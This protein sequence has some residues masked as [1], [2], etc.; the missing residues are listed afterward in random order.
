MTKSRKKLVRAVTHWFAYYIGIPVIYALL[1]LLRRT[2][3]ITRGDYT[4]VLKQPIIFAVWHGEMLIGVTEIPYFKRDIDVLASRSRDGELLSRFI[5]IAGAEAI[6]GS[7]SSGQFGAIRSMRGS[8]D[9]GRSVALA[10]DGPRGPRAIVK[11][12]VILLA[13]MT[14]VPI[15]PSVMIP[16]RYWQF[17]SWDRAILPKPFSRIDFIPGEPLYVPPQANK[18]TIERCRTRLEK[19]LINLHKK[20]LLQEGDRV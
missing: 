11:S 10:V 7:S 3:R 9:Q 6:R 4:W 16:E 19:Q 5:R 17:K 14:G 18:D 12:G 13:S 1:W 8:L 15:V 2:W 20:K